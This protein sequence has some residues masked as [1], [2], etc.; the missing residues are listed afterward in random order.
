MML[1][2]SCANFVVDEGLC[3][4]LDEGKM[5]MWFILMFTRHLMKHI[6]KI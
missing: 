1:S 4:M 3:K 5:L 6:M 2:G